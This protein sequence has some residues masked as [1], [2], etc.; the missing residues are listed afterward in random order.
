MSALPRPDL[1]P[2]PHRDLVTE[3]HDLHHRAGWPSLRSLAR[4]TGMSHTSVSHAFSRPGLPSWGTVE[5]LVEAMGGDTTRFHHLWL[6]ASTPTDDARAPA[7]QIAGR[8]TELEVA[9]R[10]LETG[11]GLLLVTGEAGIGKTT[12][13]NTAAAST[14]VVVALGRCRPLATPVALL[15]WGDLLRELLLAD[16]GAWFARA[17]ATSPAYV[18]DALGTVLPELEPAH[19]SPHP[20]DFARHRLLLAVSAVLGALSADR[21]LAVLL[22]DLP[23][24]DSATLDLLELLA[25]GHS[26]VPLVATWRTDDP[27]TTEE[28]EAWRMRI[29]RRSRRIHLGPLTRE[30]TAQQ[31]TILT[32]QVPDPADLDRVYGRS[33]GQPLFT[34]QLVGD[35]PRRGTLPDDLDRV[36]AR[37]L[38]HLDDDAWRLARA[39]GIADRPLEVTHVARAADVGDPTPGLRTLIRDRLVVADGE[40]VVLGHPLV[41]E[42][43]RN[44]LVPG[45]ASEVHARV[46]ELLATLPDPP[47]AE[48]AGHWRAA[49]DP[50]RELEWRLR[51]ATAADQRFARQEAYA[52]WL[53]VLA[54]WQECVV[55]DD[56]RPVGLAE[57]HT[58]IIESG[59]GAGLEVAEVKRHIDAAMATDLPEQ[60]RAEILLRAGDLECGFGDVVL[61]LR[62]LDEAVA[63][64][65]RHPPTSEAGHILEVRANIRFYLGLDSEAASDVRRGLEIAEAIGDPHLH[66]TML[67]MSAWVGLI[68]GDPSVAA[69][70]A[71]QA[72][73]AVAPLDDPMGCLRAAAAEVE[74]LRAICAPVSAVVAATEDALEQM[75]L[76]GFENVFADA[77]SA[78]LGEAYLL[79]GDVAAAAAVVEARAAGRTGHRLMSTRTTL[80]SVQIA[81]GELDAALAHLDGMT[82]L[83]NYAAKSVWRDRVRAQALLW[84]GRPGEA[85]AAMDRALAFVRTNG[86]AREAASLLA[87]RAR[88]GADSAR[89]TGSPDDE[90]LRALLAGWPTDPFGATGI[91]AD[92]RAWA[93]VWESEL[94][95]AAGSDRPETWIRAAEEWNRLERPHEAG[96]CRWRAAQAALREGRGTVAQRLLRRAAAD[97]REH[98]P[99]SQAIDTTVATAP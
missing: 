53:R 18:A 39:L 35:G 36:L 90:S 3:L 63:I 46:A 57:V 64:V 45:E 85:V 22:E 78:H 4:A 17:L 74:I 81:R 54:L 75:E 43:I 10:H 37:R 84:A 60:G 47:S 38:E 69:E 2:G 33:G 62:H 13:V 6:T 21:P 14:G 59:V 91:P 58:R 67:A 77:V 20:P 83:D 29:G 70:R 52:Q 96:Y 32:G 34:E 89:Q 93:V 44:R 66:R 28:R 23:W 87:T 40:S 1:P 88:A 7:P 76:W 72:R 16:D 42:A 86:L 11:T 8:R 15:P 19:R 25:D 49:K 73:R 82:G 51:A 56:E 97:A 71:A 27:E 31:L 48:I 68:D 55:A 99:L 9:R 98:V 61:G 50:G 30:E 95:R 92:R 79:A 41:G 80:C 65:E 94:A 26:P 12:L 24:A 5:V